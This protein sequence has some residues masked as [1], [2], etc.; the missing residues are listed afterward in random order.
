MSTEESTEKMTPAPASAGQDALPK[1]VY[2]SASWAA[3]QA[4]K[5]GKRQVI[6]REVTETETVYA[7]PDGTTTSEISV[8]PVRVRSS[9]GGWAKPDATLVR[10]ADGMVGPRA[11]SVEMA[12]SAG[13]QGRPLVRY[14]V[15]GATVE[16]A[17]PWRLPEP[18]L[19]GNKATYREVL[20]GVDLELLV[21]AV[22][23]A[24][25]LIVHSREAARHPALRELRLGLRTTGATWTAHR[26]G[27]LEARRSSGS[28]AFAAA[29]ATMWDSARQ[30]R[31]A[32]VGVTVGRDTMVLRP[33]Q[34]MLTAPG[35]TYPVSIDPDLSPGLYGLAVV[36]SG[37]PDQTYWQGGDDAIAKVGTCTGWYGCNG[38]NI[39]RSYF[40]WNTSTL[41]GKRI[42][43]AEF[44]AFET[45]SPSC[46]ARPVEAKATRPISTTTTWNRQPGELASLGSRTVAHGYSAS[47]PPAW[48]GWNAMGAF[49]ADSSGVHR[50]DADTTIV[51]RAPVISSGNYE[52]DSLA[53]KKFDRNPT[54]VVE[55]NTRPN[56][57]YSLSNEAGVACGSGAG[58]PA[59]NPAQTS[60]AP[61]GPRLGSRISDPDG[62][63]VRA[64]YE[65][66]ELGSGTR[67]WYSFAATAASGSPFFVDVPADK[68]VDGRTYMWRVVGNDFV[69]DG[70][71]GPWCE[72]IV[73]RTA[74]VT[75]AV[76]SADGLYPECLFPDDATDDRCSHTGGAGK[77]GTFRFE[78]S[79]DVTAFRYTIEGGG[80]IEQGSVPATGGVASAARVTPPTQGT[81]RLQVWAVDK[82][83]NK[84]VQPRVY[85]L[86]VGA[87][88]GPVGQWHLDGLAE[89]TAPDATANH[90]DG[91][92]D[93]SVTPWTTGRLRSA[94]RL[95][96]TGGIGLGSAGP[97]HTNR[98][99]TVSAWAMLTAA[100]DNAGVV[101]SQN[102]ATHSVFQLGYHAATK[103]WSMGYRDGPTSSSATRVLS[104]TPAVPGRWTHLTG[105]FNADV[106]S[107]RLYVDGVLQGTTTV[108]A[109]WDGTG[110]LQIGRNQHAGG[111]INPFR[112]AVDEVAVYDRILSAD[113]IHDLAVVDPST[114]ELRLPFGDGE[115]GGTGDVSGYY[116][117]ATLAG[118]TSWVRGKHD[119]PAADMGSAL[120]LAGGTAMSSPGL[121]TDASYTVNTWVRLDPSCAD[122][123]DVCWQDAGTANQVVLEQRGTNAA[124]LQLRYNGTLKRWQFAAAKADGTA[125]GEAVVTSSAPAVANTWTLLTGVHDQASGVL[126]LYVDAQ[127]QGEVV[128]TVWSAAGGLWIGSTTV[129][130]RGAVDEVRAWSGART[131]DQIKA[132]LV[133]AAPPVD[134][135]HVGQLSR[136]NVAG[137]HVVTTGPVHPAAYFEHPLGFP[138]PV[139]TSGT[140]TIYSCRNHASDYF[141]SAAADCEGKTVLGVVGGFYVTAP[142]ASA[143]PVYRCFVPG[144]DHFASSQADCEGQTTEF[145]LGWTQGYRHLIRY[146]NSGAPYDHT[147]TP[148]RVLSQYHAEWSLG[149]MAASN[150]N[151]AHLTTAL[152]TC[153]IAAT[154]DLFSSVD[155]ACEGHEVVQ[156]VGFV[157]TAPPEGVPA[158]QLFRCV[159]NSGERFDASVDVVEGVPV[160]PNCGPGATVDRALGYLRALA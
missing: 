42:L 152:R 157:W 20:P 84:S 142:D 139:G 53:W 126:R 104:R 105:V 156:T 76:T 35:T 132:T 58:R 151:I 46:T 32:P 87:G 133:E 78:S 9:G 121:R 102:G 66:R 37:Y 125:A 94:L 138:T 79:T 51:L 91:V 89:T 18:V 110:P 25:R 33:D 21:S 47:C 92:V 7:N 113:D 95:P 129:P 141:L 15:P 48:V 81:S 112:G 14:A 57:P 130:L 71:V 98:S 62:G 29:P 88:A 2:G 154:G 131:P 160:E 41:V 74:P 93:T 13:G 16:V 24:Q 101:L 65:W 100:D 97:V 149:I 23:Y 119:D 140:R 55:Y 19:T 6:E 50:A 44:N 114:L 147:S 109:P 54:L 85:W 3:E 122:P 34:A 60:G 96:G 155:S 128:P 80:T 69:E 145:L 136:F 43:S 49:P 26:D 39:H 36:S 153:R 134:P 12:F 10:R 30:R 27:A 31:T 5:T 63:S 108:G 1:P 90:R 77:S 137:V 40:Q 56:A 64:W 8:L 158:K 159:S 75:P 146:V 82:A 99:F 68:A 118:A 28:L 11:A 127:L 120:Q 103:G 143:V 4:A 59:I 144:K 111:Y 70:P 124:A 123:D 135:L 52:A 150:W 83:G 67:L 106:K 22:G 17:W 45:W 148:F 116:R 117:N 73:D 107:L 38:A 61:R 86:K 115:E 72:V